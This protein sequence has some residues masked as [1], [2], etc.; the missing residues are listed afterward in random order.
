MTLRWLNHIIIWLTAL[1][2]TA[3]IICAESAAS[4]LKS[5]ARSAYDDAEISKYIDL[6]AARGLVTTAMP[7]PRTPERVPSPLPGTRVSESIVTYIKTG[8]SAGKAII[9]SEPL[10]SGLL[11][12]QEGTTPTGETTVQYWVL[13]SGGRRCILSGGAT[14]GQDGQL[15]TSNFWRNDPQLR[16]A[17]F[18]ELPGDVFPNRIPPNAFL[19]ALDAP[20]PNA[21][22]K[23]NMAIGSYG[24]MTFDLWAEDIEQTSVPAGTFQTLKVIAR[25]DTDSAMK[26]WPALLT[27]LAEPF[28]PK[29]I[30][31]YDTTL[32]HHLVKFVGSLGYLAP[33]VTVQMSRVYIVSKSMSQGSFAP[34]I[35]HDKSA[36]YPR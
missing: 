4:D 15:L 30:L 17:G 16:F 26:G 21:A 6:V 32:P 22:G 13:E 14:Y 23:L 24:Y 25:V 31:Y 3:A 27:H 11:E 8:A 35:S 19:Y 2:L 28:M 36:S 12:F 20:E 1:V 33:D 10:G 5:A 34:S 9:W 7:D 29:N 18:A